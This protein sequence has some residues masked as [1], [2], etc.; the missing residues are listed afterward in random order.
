MTAPFASIPVRGR[1]TVPSPVRGASDELAEAAL[2]TVLL[3]GVV[4]G[5]TVL[6]RAPLPEH[7]VRTVRCS[8][9]ETGAYVVSS[10]AGLTATSRATGGEVTSFRCTVPDHLFALYAVTAARASATCV[11]TPCGGSSAVE[12]AAVLAR[13]GLRARAAGRSVVIEPGFVAGDGIVDHA[14]DIYLVLSTLLVGLLRFGTRIVDTAPLDIRMPDFVDTW[15]ALLV[16][17]EFLLPGSA[18][19]PSDY[20]MRRP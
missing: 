15:S 7:I 2:T 20:I 9:A 8:V 3:A 17:D 14:G 10:A 18:L 1:V 11:L 16:A 4:T 13:L 12:A 5:G 6:A 19:V